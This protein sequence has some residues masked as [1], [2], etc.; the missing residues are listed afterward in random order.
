MAGV[1]TATPVL[2]IDASRNLQSA[3]EIVGANDVRVR[4]VRG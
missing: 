4:F 1:T 3:G 2:M